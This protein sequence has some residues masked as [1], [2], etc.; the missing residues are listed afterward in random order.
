M[1]VLHDTGPLSVTASFG[2]AVY[3]EQMTELEDLIKLAD[4]ALYKAKNSGRNVVCHMP[5]NQTIKS[6]EVNKM[7][8][9]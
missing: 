8:S 2:V 3:N 7:T 4:V 5:Q 9:I 1:T 6:Q